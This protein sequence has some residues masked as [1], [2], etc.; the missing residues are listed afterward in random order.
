MR[1]ADDAPQESGHRPSSPKRWA[2]RTLFGAASVAGLAAGAGAFSWR[3]G[4][5]GNAGA[6]ADAQG[7]P[8]APRTLSAQTDRGLVLVDAVADGVMR[9]RV[10]DREPSSVLR[11]YAIPRELSSRDAHLDTGA[12]VST[13]ATPEITVALDTH[14]GAITARNRSGAPF[15]Q[16]S[17]TG[18]TVV[19]DGFRW[20]L[21]LPATE[22]CHGLGLRGFPLSLRHR[23]LTLWNHDARSYP[24]GT[25]PLYL[26]VPFYLG[27]R[28]DLSYGIFWDNPARGS[29]DLDSDKRGLLTY[30][31]EHRPMTMYL[32]AADGPQQVVQRFAELTGLMELPPLWSLGYQQSRWSYLDEDHVRRVADRMRAE[33]IPCDALHFDIDYMDGFRVFTWN[34]GRFPNPERLLADL[35]EKSFESVAILDPGVKVDA[36]YAVYREAKSRALFLTKPSGARLRRE[37]W[38]G[39]S[40]FPDFTSPVCRDW[41]ADQVKSFA[42]VGFAGLWNDMNEPS[43]FTEPRTLPDDTPHDWEGQGATHV[44]GG[45]AVYGMQMARASRDGL[46]QLHADRRPFVISRAGYAG[47]QRYAAVWNGDSLATWDHLRVTVPQLL[48]LGMSGIPFAGS[49]AGGF[50]GN[51]DSE[52]YL[53]WMQLASMTPFFRTHS[54]RTARERN[55]WTYG[56]TMTDRLRKVVELRYRL[57]PYFY[58]AVQRACS[59][60]VPV[61]R[62]MFFESPDDPGY[63]DLGDQFMVGADLLI[64]PILTK[65]ARSRSVVLPPGVWYRLD[66]TDTITG[67][68]T[69]VDR[70]GLGLP[71]FVRAGT[72]LPTWPV[73]QS[74]AEPPQRLGL[75]V[76]AGER[77]SRLY[78][79]AG[80]GYGYREDQ[81]L[82]NTFTTRPNQ[83]RLIVSCKR[84]GAFV[85]AYDQIDLEFRG[86]PSAS[87][88]SVDGR[89]LPT[90]V[91]GGVVTARVGRFEMAE[92]RS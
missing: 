7:G 23:R 66:G 84:E 20:Q 41:W 92:L 61:L 8:T 14:T 75:T 88:L 35:K 28:P 27:H 69:L 40:E 76:Y 2:R 1:S 49:D 15:I 36:A 31:C 43:T 16:E 70:A 4:W 6:N 73:R 38:A 72:V 64:A 50:R 46:A 60:G 67:G 5:F 17:G 57:L 91:D 3:A 11:S 59:E 13:L 68:R 71:I 42:A 29:L 9:V 37:V 33:R 74:T 25:D 51:P 39:P 54:A 18:F 19:R 22:S 78:E 56:A 30:E 58:T 45:H 65:G 34:S 52:L 85:P 26:S 32:I 47:S 77:S 21:A 44:T 10:L 53:R 86:V 89:Q 55:P 79:D 24:A 48:N 12:G 63:Q 90:N 62:P 81:W 82:I 83:G 87:A 80:D